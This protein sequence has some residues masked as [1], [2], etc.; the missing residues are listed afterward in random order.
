MQVLGVTVGRAAGDGTGGH[1]HSSH[2][3]LHFGTPFSCTV[4]GILGEL[5]DFCTKYKR[6]LEPL[7]H[8]NIGNAEKKGALL[9]EW[10]KRPEDWPAL[11]QLSSEMKKWILP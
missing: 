10:K 4:T 7:V 5:V 9:K 1:K 3:A 11:G 6:S 8:Q 2:P